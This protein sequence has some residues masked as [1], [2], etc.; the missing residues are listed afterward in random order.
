M[1]V[2]TESMSSE[3][4]FV[5]INHPE[6]ME[7]PTQASMG[8]SHHTP[9]EFIP[10]P[11]VPFLPILGLKPQNAGPCSFTHVLMRKPKIYH[12]RKALVMKSS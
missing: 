9:S 10:N 12:S 4:V 2:S 5:Q 6:I 1:D 7:N 8:E 11:R 3:E